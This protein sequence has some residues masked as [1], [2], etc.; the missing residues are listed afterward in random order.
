MGLAA[1]KLRLVIGSVY[2]LTLVPEYIGV[3]G[4][5]PPGAENA[6]FSGPKNLVNVTP[7]PHS[8]LVDP[9]ETRHSKNAPPI[10]GLNA[11][12]EVDVQKGHKPDHSPPECGGN[13]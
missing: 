5:Q 3:R 4:I 8:N 10:R 7:S 13:H 2:G 11:S 6:G 12:I 1:Y 9:L